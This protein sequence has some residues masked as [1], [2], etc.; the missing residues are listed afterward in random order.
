MEPDELARRGY[1][2]SRGERI[3]RHL[4]MYLQRA[5]VGAISGVAV[6]AGFL[7]A[8]QVTWPLYV[9]L[10]LT[11][12][13]IGLCLPGLALLEPGRRHV[14]VG[15]V[16]RRRR[17]SAARPPALPP[18]PPV[19]TVEPAPIA[20]VM[21]TACDDP[22]YLSG[23]RSLLPPNQ[24]LIVVPSGLSDVS[25]PEELLWPLFEHRLNRSHL[26]VDVRDFGIPLSPYVVER[27]LS[28]G[29]GSAQRLL[30]VRDLT[31][32]TGLATALVAGTDQPVPQ[33]TPE[34]CVDPVQIARHDVVIVGGPDTNFW[35]AVL[36][37]PLHR[38][39][40]FPASSVPLAFGMRRE[41]DG[42]VPVYGN[43]IASVVSVDAGSDP[44]HA[45]GA[46]FG[47]V[48]QP[49]YGMI[50]ACRNP[51][52]AAL[53][54]SRWCVFVAGTTSLGTAGAVLALSRILGRLSGDPDANVSTVVPTVHPQVRA[55]V[56]AVLCRVTEVEQSY[57]RSNGRVI[58]RQRRPLPGEGP[59]PAEFDDFWLPTR[60][61]VLDCS[62]LQP[63][64]SPV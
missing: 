42:G 63:R 33:L 17:R 25:R 4:R 10:L 18:L 47:H 1:L 13:A 11:L 44:R 7:S 14:L 32:T 30:P 24:P 6:L 56:S 26:R 51:L 5:V 38:E 60:C 41:R 53:G 31:F 36:F 15:R 21:A 57:V 8:A 61:E 59:V 27:E 12:G 2:V 54:I 55:Q 3:R 62:D 34:H 22:V 46:V 43:A 64:W 20:P 35:H 50:L 29:N 45:P 40:A 23:L 58:P 37:E 48:L 9:Y 28:G 19:P 16:L 39:F 49:T 52:A